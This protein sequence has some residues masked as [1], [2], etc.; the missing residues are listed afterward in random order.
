MGDSSPSDSLKGIGALIRVTQA[1]DPT[2]AA[3]FRGEARALGVSWSGD[4]ELGDPDA[5]KPKAHTVEEFQRELARSALSS[6]A[7]DLHPR[8]TIVSRRLRVAGHLSF[9]GKL[10]PAITAAGTLV[11]LLGLTPEQAAGVGAAATTVVALLKITEDQLVAFVAGGTV[12]ALTEL[13]LR[14]Q[15][16]Q[17][18]ASGV[19]ADFKTLDRLGAPV[20]LYPTAEAKRIADEAG[21]L[22]PRLGLV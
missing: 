12:T 3:R 5:A 14:S 22:L 13:L 17:R 8:I 16:V 20:D 11:A 2:A 21:D 9:I 7:K 19:L 6:V 1:L 18:R 15:T 10:L 4:I